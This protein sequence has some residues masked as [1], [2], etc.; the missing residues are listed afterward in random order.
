MQN[1]PHFQCSLFIPF[2]LC[3]TAGILFYGHVFAL[4]HQ[5]YEQF[6]IHQLECPWENWFH[7]P[8]WVVPVKH[9]EAHY[10][11]PV[12][13]G[14]ECRF[15]LVVDFIGTTSFSVITSLFQQNLC[16]TVKTVHVFCS[17]VTKQK[18]PIPPHFLTR[19][20]NQTLPKLTNS[21]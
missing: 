18:I 14:E 6:V 9:A 7:H 5:A 4:A 16:C 3:D 12:K 1:S 10:H 19:L 20:Q 8:D 11:S 13:A 21:H 15:E 17:P 2:H